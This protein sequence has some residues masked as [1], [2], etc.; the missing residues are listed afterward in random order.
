MLKHYLLVIAVLTFAFFFLPYWMFIGPFIGLSYI[1]IIYHH[2]ERIEK[3]EKKK[4][5]DDER[6]GKNDIKTDERP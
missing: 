6:H 2:A 1:Y 4:K 3:K 5:E